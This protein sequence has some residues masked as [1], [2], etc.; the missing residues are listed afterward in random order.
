MTIWSSWR[1]CRITEFEFTR[2]SAIFDLLDIPLYHGWIVDP[3]VF[4]WYLQFRSCYFKPCIHCGIWSFGLFNYT[5]RSC[6]KSLVFCVLENILYIKLTPGKLAIQRGSEK[7]IP[8][9]VM[10]LY[11]LSTFLEVNLKR[12]YELKTKKLKWTWH[13]V[14]LDHLRWQY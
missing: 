3:Q 9:G 6:R 13:L 8:L 1:S 12:T 2:E 5:L 11:I 4:E 10:F 14:P 7:M